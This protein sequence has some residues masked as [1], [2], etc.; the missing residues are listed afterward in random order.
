MWIHFSTL[1]P[2]ATFWLN[3]QF[4]IVLQHPDTPGGSDCSFLVGLMQKDRRRK[5][6]E[7]QDMET[8]GFA[9]YE[10]RDLQLCPVPHH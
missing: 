8:I 2:P 1:L 7:G 9:L 6:Q 10:V 4:K 5:R 3:P